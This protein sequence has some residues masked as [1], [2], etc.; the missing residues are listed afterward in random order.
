MV[1]V[2][3][4]CVLGLSFGLSFLL[5]KARPLLYNHHS[6]YILKIGVY[7]LQIL[8]VVVLAPYILRSTVFD[9]ILIAILCLIIFWSCIISF[10]TYYG[11]D[12]IS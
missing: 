6:N 3:L 2:A 9:F 5:T 11:R 7:C 1:S 4:G 10:M 8:L 12:N